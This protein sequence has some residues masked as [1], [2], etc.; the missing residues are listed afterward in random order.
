[1]NVILYAN[2]SIN[3]KVLLS[4]YANHQLSEK[5]FQVNVEDIKEAGT[6]IM[7]R[8]SYDAFKLAVNG[9]ENIKNILSG[10]ELVSLSSKPDPFGIISVADSPY[11][12]ITFLKEKGYKKILVGGG[13][14]TY[15]TFLKANLVTEIILNILPI[16]TVGGDWF[17]PDELNLKFEL[18][19]HKVINQDVIQ[20]LYTR[21]GI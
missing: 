2:V 21:K 16:I 17:A 5:V 1:M 20:L 11:N 13:T 9:I 4:E 7:G 6:L 15:N 12:A 14:E 18:K 10:V 19:E 3:G 8:K